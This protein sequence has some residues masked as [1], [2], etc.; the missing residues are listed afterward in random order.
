M[1]QATP[2]ITAVNLRAPTNVAGSGSSSTYVTPLGSTTEP[3]PAVADTVYMYYAFTVTW[4]YD[5][6]Y[7]TGIAD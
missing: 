1:Y 7:F 4:S 5:S 6:Y 2:T 3:P